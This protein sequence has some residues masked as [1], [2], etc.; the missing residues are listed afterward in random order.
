MSAYCV[1]AD[2]VNGG[3]R[4]AAVDLLPDPD[5]LIVRASGLIDSFLRG[6]YHLPFAVTPAELKD[7]C[8]QITLWYAL[9][10]L[11]WDPESKTDMSI[12]MGHD[13]AMKWLDRVSNGKAH[14][15]VSADSTPEV[16]DGIPRVRSNP[17]N[18][19]IRRDGRI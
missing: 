2:L 5:A 8:V 7:C 17:R 19:G 11:G 14:L 18:C 10:S 1:E 16:S 6:R 12:R 13:D 9:Q 15:S 3:L 4:Q